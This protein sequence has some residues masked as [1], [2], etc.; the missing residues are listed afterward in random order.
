MNSGGVHAPYALR[1]VLE[2]VTDD[3]I[4]GISE[5]PGNVETNALLERS[6][7]L[8]S[9]ADPF[10]LNGIRANIY[11]RYGAVE[12]DIRGEYPWDRRKLVHVY[13]AIEVACL[14]IQGKIC[15]RPVVDLLGGSC[16]ERVPFSAYLFYKFRGAGGPLGHE[17]HPDAT[18]W[19]AARQAEALDPEQIVAQARA[20]IKE[21]GFKSIKLKGGVFPP[22]E[23]VKAIMRLWETFGPD[24]PLRLDPNGVWKVE[25]A[26]EYGKKLEGVLE[27]LQDPGA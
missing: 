1:T 4:T 27:Y 3:N 22:G 9:G 14:D 25:T 26:I 6:G 19:D 12:T 18:G 16:R 23:E 2:L 11:D 8:I 20:M 13:S 5:I 17:T 10:Q 7:E 21:F 15:G 24:V